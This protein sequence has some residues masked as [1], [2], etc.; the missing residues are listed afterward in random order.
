MSNFT[1][2][3]KI[4]LLILENFDI[5]HMYFLFINYLERSV[6]YVSTQNTLKFIL[7]LF[8]KEG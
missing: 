8:T 4:L 2:L 1:F 5:I 6:F 7:Q 3:C